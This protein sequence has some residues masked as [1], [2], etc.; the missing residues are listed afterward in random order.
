MTATGL[1]CAMAMPEV[2]ESILSDQ[3]LMHASVGCH[4]LSSYVGAN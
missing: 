4:S 2:N 3:K 1:C